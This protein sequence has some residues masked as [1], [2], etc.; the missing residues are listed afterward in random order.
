MKDVSYCLST[1]YPQ[2]TINKNSF[3]P[4]IRQKVNKIVKITQ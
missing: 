1:N 2:V 3:L 4:H